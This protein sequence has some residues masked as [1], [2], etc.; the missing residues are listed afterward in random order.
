MAQP[1]RTYRDLEAWKHAM[2]L[3]EVVYT[4]TRSL[5]QDERFGLVAQMRRCALSVASNIAE[6]WG[7]GDT[8][9]FTR[10]LLMSRGSL[11][12]LSTQVEACVM[13]DLGG[14]WSGVN[15]VLEE[16]SRTLQG[17]IKSRSRDSL[18]PVST[19]H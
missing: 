10:F 13:L 11:F 12:E 3:I 7:R 6:G 1:V 16:T 8:R 18:S 15:E 5:P 14:D 19:N 9:D 17:L 2:R 4:E